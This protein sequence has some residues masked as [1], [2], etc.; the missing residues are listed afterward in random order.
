MDKQ[1]KLDTWKYAIGGAIYNSFIKAVKELEEAK[2][3]K[4]PYQD[5]E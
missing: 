5:E 1:L 2:L 4:Q 3:E